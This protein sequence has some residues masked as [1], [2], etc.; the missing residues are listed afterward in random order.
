[1]DILKRDLGY[2][3]WMMQGDFSLNTKN[4]LTRIR[5]RAINK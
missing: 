1:E 2:Y 4:V 5:L 3:G